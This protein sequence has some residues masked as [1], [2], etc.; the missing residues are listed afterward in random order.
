MLSKNTNLQTAL[1][2][3]P[4]VADSS[5]ALGLPRELRSGSLTQCGDAVD[6][7]APAD[8][9]KAFF[10]MLH[11]EA[12]ISLAVHRVGASLVLE[13][14]EAEPGWEASGGSSSTAAAP[15]ADSPS[16][17][18]LQIA[19]K[20][21][22]NRF[23]TY[24]MGSVEQQASSSSQPQR[25]HDEAELHLSGD[26]DEDDDDEERESWM[27]P[28]QPPRG[29]RRVVR[30]QL[31]ELSLLLGSDTVIFRHGDN[32][33]GSLDGI[34]NSADGYHAPGFSVALHDENSAA[35]SMVCLDYW[36]DNVMSNASD[37]ALCLH[38]DGV[39]QG[40][41]VVPTSELPYGGN[42][43]GDGFSPAA[44]TECAVSVLRFLRQHCTREAGTYWLVRPHGGDEL[45]LFDITDG[46]PTTATGGEGCGGACGGA[47][48]SARRE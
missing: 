44:V 12:A 42:G 34:C 32:G 25:A 19:R 5:S 43:L 38:T 28:K 11:T 45:R 46:P 4:S 31:D 6:F 18:A 13:G 2:A 21:M 26:S 17:G 33:R 14:L 7:I 16:A 29:F 23:I 8:N 41:R 3:V 27:P 36:L 47:S 10:K 15:A 22:Q 30:W 35:T 40:Y 48:G 39:V 20:A 1:V 9:M 24:S 37:V